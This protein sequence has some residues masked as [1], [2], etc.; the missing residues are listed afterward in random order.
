MKFCKLRQPEIDWLIDGANLTTEEE[1]IF[2]MLCK[3]KSIIYI[4]DNLNMSTRT[5]DRRISD[6]KRK[7]NI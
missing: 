3:G 4:A 6:I 2:Q 5:I 1:K 7:L